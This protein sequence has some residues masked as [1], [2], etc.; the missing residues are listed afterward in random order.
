V[1]LDI[2]GAGSKQQT[3][4]L[5]KKHKLSDRVTL[6]GF[7]DN[8]QMTNILSHYNAFIMPTTSETFGMV[9][10]EAL[11]A[12]IPIIYSKEQGIDGYFDDAD[13]GSAV[14][15]TSVNSVHQAILQT[16]ENYDSLKENVASLQQNNGLRRFQQSSIVDRYD[17]IIRGLAK[18]R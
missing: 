1:T 11:S 16:I 13:I 18:H 14:D 5:V 8:T 15:P 3:K 7:V 2:Y 9:Y 4:Q 17:T 10:I 12:G 6:K